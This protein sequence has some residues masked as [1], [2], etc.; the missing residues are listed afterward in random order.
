MI[1]IHYV[2]LWYISGFMPTVLSTRQPL[3][4]SAKAENRCIL[5]VMFEN[6]NLKVTIDIKIV[7]MIQLKYVA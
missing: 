5:V 2:H 7:I 4:D 6:R 1:F 3:G